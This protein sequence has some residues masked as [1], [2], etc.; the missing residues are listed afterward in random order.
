MTLVKDGLTINLPCEQAAHEYSLCKRL[1][2]FFSGCPCECL[3]IWCI[4][5]NP[6]WPSLSCQKTNFW[7]FELLVH[8]K[9]WFNRLYSCMIQPRGESRE[10]FNYKLLAKYNGSNVKIFYIIFIHG[11]NMISISADIFKT[12]Q[13]SSGFAR[14]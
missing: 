3:I 13:I 14:I 12:E 10:F 2:R 11:F 1:F 8:D 6:R 9:I 5:E 4:I 7:V